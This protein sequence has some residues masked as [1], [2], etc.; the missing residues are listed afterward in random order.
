M[1]LVLYGQPG[2]VLAVRAGGTILFTGFVFVD[3][4]RIRH[5]FGADDYIPAT[6]EVYLDLI[7]LFLFILRLLGGSRRN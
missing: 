3:F 6:M 1:F 4:T 7:N 5:N 2:D